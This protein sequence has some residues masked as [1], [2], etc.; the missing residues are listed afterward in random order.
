MID[1]EIIKKKRRPRHS[2][3]KDGKGKASTF[4]TLAHI[5]L[6]NGSRVDIPKHPSNTSELTTYDHLR[7]AM[8]HAALA[9]CCLNRLGSGYTPRLA[10]S[11]NLAPVRLNLEDLMNHLYYAIQGF[12]SGIG[13]T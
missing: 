6:I 4:P 8:E 1:D 13:S 2:S 10:D 11:H 5:V 3:K 12:P 9:T 7:I